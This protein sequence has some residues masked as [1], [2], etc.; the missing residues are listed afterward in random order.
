MSVTRIVASPLGPVRLEVDDG[1]LV[2]V[3]FIDAADT[4]EGIDGHAT[5]SERRAA[6]ASHADARTTPRR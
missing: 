3:A 2:G 6:R 5:T 4:P 1:A